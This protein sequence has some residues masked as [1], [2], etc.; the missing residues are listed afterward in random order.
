G[1][2]QSRHLRYVDPRR[3]RQL[4]TNLLSN[5]FSALAA[6]PG[7]ESGI[8]IEAREQEGKQILLFCNQGSPIPEVIRERIFMPFVSRFEGGTGLGLAIVARIME[9]HGGCVNLIER[10]GWNTCFKLSFPKRG[11]DGGSRAYSVGG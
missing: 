2:R 9:A 7:A 8:C 3:F 4:L 6:S 5:A 1:C 10:E 11:Q